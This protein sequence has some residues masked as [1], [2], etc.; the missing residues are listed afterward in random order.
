MSV[1]VSQLRSDLGILPLRV[2]AGQQ[3]KRGHH[4]VGG[5]RGLREIA[6]VAQSGQDCLSDAAGGLQQTSPACDCTID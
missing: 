6:H 5:Q 2:V 4:R 1:Q 3:E